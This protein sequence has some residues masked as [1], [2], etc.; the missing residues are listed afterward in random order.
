MEVEQVNPGAPPQSR[1]NY[2]HIQFGTAVVAVTLI[3]FILIIASIALFAVPI[4]EVADLLLVISGEGSAPH[5]SSHLAVSTSIYETIITFLIAMNAIIAGVSILY[6]KTNTEDKIEEAVSKESLNFFKSKKFQDELQSQIKTEG[7]SYLVDAQSD[8][9][10]IYEKFDS[11]VSLLGSVTKSVERLE[12][13]NSDLR[14]LI[15][16]LAKRISYLDDSEE[17]GNKER[18]RD[19]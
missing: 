16:L 4:S 19:N 5:N 2:S 17:K 6:I 11:S 13:D 7:K 1:R 18:L 15:A 8:L 10:D 14:E 12:K 3:V 9:K